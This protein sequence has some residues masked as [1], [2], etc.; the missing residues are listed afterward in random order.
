MLVHAHP[1]D[2]TIATGATMA[3]YAS[4]GAGVTLVT[5]TLGEQGAIVVKDLEHLA[6]S[7]DDAL[8]PH[9]LGELAAAMAELGVSDFV[10]LGADFK[11]RDSGMA[12]DERGL[13]VAV[14]SEDQ[15]ES[16]WTADLLAATNDLVP[17]IRNRQPQVLIT[18]DE[19]GGYGHPDHVMAHRITMYAAQLAAISSYR[20]DLGAAWQV[21]RV[22]WTAIPASGMRRMVR[23]RRANGDA[24]AFGGFDPES[25]DLPPMSV[26]DE[27]ID[28]QVDGSQWYEAKTAALRAHRSQVDWESW[29]G[30]VGEAEEFRMFA[31]ESFRLAS[32]VPLPQDARPAADIFAGLNL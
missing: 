19:N 6:A 11:Y 15:H 2:E 20:P 8:G 23:L 9:R 14:A 24:E 13:A 22:L 4:E 7:A 16:F 26:A 31:Q 27:Q 30:R 1:D 25:S 10:R 3:R 28:V 21:S 18:Y 29:W 12:Y 32:G 5:C 17:L